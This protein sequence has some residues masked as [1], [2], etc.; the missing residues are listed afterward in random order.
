MSKKNKLMLVAAIAAMV[1]LIGS[2]VARC[3][4]ER[5]DADE[6]K[7]VIEAV[8]EKGSGG[9]ASAPHEEGH[10]TQNVME[11]PGDNG[12]D[13]LIGSS[14]QSQDDPTR[15]LAIVKGAFVETKD[16]QTDVTYW[17][18]DSEDN[19]GDTITAVILASKSMADAAAPVTL[20]VGM[21]GGSEVLS[22]DALAAKYVRVQAGERTL[23]FDG[24]TGKLAESMG[25]DAASIE[26]AVA[27]RAAAVSPSAEHARWDAEVWCDFANNVATATFTLEGGA[28]TIIS[29]TRAADGTLEAL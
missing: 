22:C 8:E 3:T 27:A 15:T 14:W 29:V 5:T 6:A 19:R 10:A 11:E 1:L 24:V 7:D 18:V 13:S 28:S 20:T 17:T 12:I 23:A 25:A 9:E 4:L 21:E 2:G 26:A 16:G